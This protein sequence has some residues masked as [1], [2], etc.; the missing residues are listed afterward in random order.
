MRCVPRVMSPTTAG[1]I[2]PRVTVSCTRRVRAMLFVSHAM[3][4]TAAGPTARLAIPLCT[5]RTPSVTYVLPA[6]W[7]PIPV[8]RSARPVTETSMNMC[9]RVPGRSGWSISSLTL[10]LLPIRRRPHLR[11]PIP[12]RCR[13]SPRDSRMATYR[14]SLKLR[15][16]SCGWR[17]GSFCS[18]DSSP[19]GSPA[20]RRYAICSRAAGS[21]RSFATGSPP[22]PPPLS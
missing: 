12:A 15:R 6:I 8:E 2:A 22:E 14:T 16:M 13:R 20:G 7:L 1:R 18:A 17:F 9:R 5:T 21:R 10:F 11:S 3:S 4:R 19:L